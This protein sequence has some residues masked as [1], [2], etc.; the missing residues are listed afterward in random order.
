MAMR[1]PK[2]Q[3][4]ACALGAAFVVHA[5]SAAA[6]GLLQ[7]YEAALQ[8]D[9]TYRSAVHENEAG[10]ENIALGRSALL[11]NLAA[12]YTNY[13]NRADNTAPNF[14]GQE[15]TTHPQYKSITSTLQLRQSILNLEG[16]ARYQQGIA[17]S[18]YSDAVFSAR[19]K[20]LVLRLVGAYADAQYA[21]DQLALA[22][23][24]RDTFAEQMRVN[25][26]MFKQ[27][28]GTKT[29]M[30]ETRAK[31][32]VAEAQVIEARD[33]LTTARNSL[34]AIVGS[35][36][37]QLD[38]LSSEFAVLPLQPAEFEAWKSIALENNADIAA[39]RYAVEASRQDVNRNR[40]GH[41][42]RLDVVAS[43]SKTKGET[44]NTYNQ[45]AT[46]R[47]VG[48]QLNIPLYSG[49]YVNAATSQSV[50]NYEKAKSD[51][52]AKTKQVMVELQKQYSLVLS[53]ASRIEAQMKSVESASL[54]VKATE[55]SIKGGVRINLD[56]LNA[57][58]QLYTAK[59]DL[60]QAKYNYLL[61]YLRLRNAAGTLG[62]DDLHK[63]AGY[64]V[65]SSR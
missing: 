1:I 40:A 29:D 43:L 37:T 27:G 50:A 62:T 11:P 35:E 36:I 41:A 30:L 57:Q 49:G 45:D 18:D 48:V 64:F 63:V 34:A 59:R 9:P 10:H 54:L 13:K 5:G 20:D 51:L 46:V 4:L 12:S 8:N 23:A 16:V 7:A 52:E 6:L 55:Q 33:N 21:E 44:L 19:S 47:S 25:E 2:R 3:L 42:P 53:G 14:L 15:V 39:Q 60:A 31:Y 56:L 28:E 32:D 22:V 17:Q 24:Q 58:Q 61:S 65:P 38:P 26:R